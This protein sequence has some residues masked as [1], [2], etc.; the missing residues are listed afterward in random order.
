MSVRTERTVPDNGM[1]ALDLNGAQNALYTG[2]LANHVD[3][4]YASHVSLL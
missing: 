3:A 4:T 1:A 2:T